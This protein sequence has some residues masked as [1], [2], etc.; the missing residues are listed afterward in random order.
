MNSTIDLSSEA[1]IRL[2]F[3]DAYLDEFTLNLGLDPAVSP[4]HQP[5]D[6]QALLHNAVHITEQAQFRVIIQKTVTLRGELWK[7]D[8]FNDNRVYLPYGPVSALTTFTYKNL[9]AANIAFANYTTV[10]PTQRMS[11]RRTGAFS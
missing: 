6:I 9:S 5:T 10:L 3:P 1:D 8:K 2:L 4:E 11:G 7:L